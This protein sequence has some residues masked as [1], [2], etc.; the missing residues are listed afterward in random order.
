MQQCRNLWKVKIAKLSPS[1]ITNFIFFEVIIISL[2]T[3]VFCDFL[4]NENT[5][6]VNPQVNQLDFVLRCNRSW[7]SNL[8]AQNLDKQKLSTPPQSRLHD[9]YSSSCQNWTSASCLVFNRK[10]LYS[11]VKWEF[12]SVVTCFLEESKVDSDS[13]V[14]LLYHGVDIQLVN[15]SEAQKRYVRLSQTNVK[16]PL[17]ALARR[18]NRRDFY[19]VQNISFF[20]PYAKLALEVADWLNKTVLP[21]DQWNIEEDTVLSAFHT[22]MYSSLL[23]STNR[24]NYFNISTRAFRTHHFDYNFAYC[25]PPNFKGM[26]DYSILLQPFQNI[27]WISLVV[28]LVSSTAALLRKF[29]GREIISTFLS[30]VSALVSMSVVFD[31]NVRLKHSALFMSWM[32]VAVVLNNLY[33]GIL[34]SLLVKPLE[35]KTFGEIKDLV[36]N[37]YTGIFPK[38]LATILLAVQDQIRFQSESKEKQSSKI[39]DY[40]KFLVGKNIEERHL[41]EPAFTEALAYKPKL[42]LFGPWAFAI[43]GRN[44]AQARI[45]ADV[46]ISS[47]KGGKVKILKEKRSCYIGRKLEAAS[48]GV[49]CA[50]Y[51]PGVDKLYQ[52]YQRLVQTGIYLVYLNEFSGM[53]YAPKMQERLKVKSETVLAKDEDT[54]FEPMEVTQ[55]LRILLVLIMLLILC[56]VCFILEVAWYNFSR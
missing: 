10:S 49:L 19:N 11:G 13:T 3:G 48:P 34:T 20:L 16:S 12:Y 42:A 9:L 5:L 21:T 6:N 27:V 14:S 1:L 52:S 26:L 25:A 8:E 18:M 35:E 46:E 31:K 40:M 50:F 51:P 28:A 2:E 24:K 23:L 7:I 53:N 54:H 32:F 55:A 45:K 17:L 47:A 41:L 39:V 43:M 56:S 33:T 29:S 36:A 37:N 38:H 44:Q 15:P 22:C 30:L 4:Q